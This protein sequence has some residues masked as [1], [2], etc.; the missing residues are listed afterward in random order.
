MAPTRSASDTQAFTTLL[1]DTCGYT[2]EAAKHLTDTYFSNVTQFQAV[3]IAE[4]PDTL[5]AEAKNNKTTTFS[6]F[7]NT[8]L[9]A[10]KHLL[11]YHDWRGSS[12]DNAITQFATDEV[13]NKWRDRVNYLSMKKKETAEKAELPP[14]LAKLEDYPEWEDRLISYLCQVRNP[15]GIR[16]LYLLRDYKLPSAEQLGA[17]Y[18]SIDDDLV[19]TVRHDKAFYADDSGR[20]HDL[21]V[22]PLLKDTPLWH[23]VSA[24]KGGRNKSPDGAAAL[25][26]LKRAAEGDS[27]I[28]NRKQHAYK[29]LEHLNF[30]GG[31]QNI[32]TH[33]GQRRKHYNTLE[34]C[35]EAVPVLKR[36]TETLQSI[37]DSSFDLTKEL[38]FN[39]KKLMENSDELEHAIL[40]AATRKKHQPTSK[41]QTIS[42]VNSGGS[43]GGGGGKKGND[44]GK[45]RKNNDGKG[46]GGKKK[47]RIRT[48]NYENEEW[49]ALSEEEQKKVK[50]LRA[51]KK[52]KKAAAAN[53]SDEHEDSTK[54]S[55]VTSVQP[56][57]SVQEMDTDENDRK[58]AAKK[59][60]P[61][62][63]E[64]QEDDRK[65]APVATGSVNR[66]PLTRLPALD[67]IGMV[68]PD[69]SRHSRFHLR[70]NYPGFR[71]QM[72]RY[73]QDRIDAHLRGLE[74]MGRLTPES[75]REVE[76]LIISQ[77][78]PS[79]YQQLFQ[80]FVQRYELPLDLFDAETRSLLEKARAEKDESEHQDAQVA[81]AQANNA[82]AGDQFGRNAHRASSSD[83]DSEKK[84]PAKVNAKRPKDDKNSQD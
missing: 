55:A 79:V 6:H 9:I 8:T 60:K 19:A 27:A 4:L 71:P 13:K 34:A 66:L 49:W 23:F 3:S 62:P 2:A 16:L 11:N 7:T 53:T 57:A 64:P 81:A 73:L 45:K 70:I 33:L 18:S 46:K 39:D 38:I 58:P 51:Q 17:T 1:T 5:L 78:R 44:G 63:E 21:I 15:Y 75:P 54:I 22:M 28:M 67:D 36:N 77:H 14:P 42:A 76:T 32:A 52:A 65:P 43:G 82:N 29:Q 10:F 35:G 31:R 74:R 68:H 12:A 26:A 37:K 47:P 61:A 69:L 40:N 84:P 24:Y 72:E 41:G 56:E 59:L 48:S 83:E 50:L 25:L 20:L 30:T 80:E